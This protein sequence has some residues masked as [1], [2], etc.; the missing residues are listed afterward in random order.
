MPYVTEELIRS[1]APNSRFIPEL[2]V[3]LNQLFEK[4][5]INTPQR[6]AAFLSQAATE[7]DGFVWLSEAAWCSDKKAR[8]YC[9]RYEP[10]TEK[11][12]KLGNTHLGDGYLYRGRG[13]FQL[14]G[15][16]NYE[17]YS[18]ILGIDISGNP[19]ILSSNVHLACL[20]ACEYWNQ[21]NLNEWADKGSLRKITST[22]N[23]GHNKYEERKKYY[24]TLMFQLLPIK[25][26][27]I[28]AQD[29]LLQSLNVITNNSLKPHFKPGVYATLSEHCYT[30]KA[31][32]PEG[33]KVL[34]NSKKYVYD[35][36]R[37]SSFFAG[38]VKSV[39]PTS[40]YYQQFQAGFH[41]T[42]YINVNEGVVVIANAGTDFKNNNGDLLCNVI[43]DLHL[44]LRI[45][46][47][48][49]CYYDE[50]Y[51]EVQRELRNQYPNIKFKIE[52]TGHS[53]GAAR[54]QLAGV[55]YPRDVVVAFDG[56]GVRE[57]LPKEIQANTFNNVI[58]FIIDENAINGVNT[59][60]G[61]TCQLSPSESDR[62]KLAKLS[63]L[64]W[65]VKC[66]EIKTFIN[67]FDSNGEPIHHV[68]EQKLQIEKIVSQQTY[69]G[70][71][72]TPNLVNSV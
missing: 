56:P 7:T 24:N 17:R 45:I 54:V 47:A 2:V 26:Y 19:D 38:Y 48:G 57:L 53:L 12:K 66:H 32:T 18:K 36:F 59:R 43:S 25:Q 42:A 4:Y 62:I 34:L 55:V 58:N 37:T 15:R 8:E 16:Y 3:H 20:T 28:K 70:P 35:P 10:G 40:K 67:A 21:K 68:R 44:G 51:K 60:I 11:G 1:I 64:S 65:L 13:I 6:I 31:Q 5:E 46:P 39:P 69:Y 52:H 9:Q 72:I 27:E 71:T 29:N 41:A 61:T 30:P 63:G 50:F 33:F 23:G 14:T 22:I 49:Q